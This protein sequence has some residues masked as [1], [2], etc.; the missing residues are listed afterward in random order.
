MPIKSFRG[1]IATS[2]QERIALHTNNGMTGY[3]IVKM[4]LMPT[5][6]G[7]SAY[8]NVFKVYS[9]LQTAVDGEIDFSDPTL[10]G[11]AYI[12]NNGNNITNDQTVVV[13]DNIIFNQDIHLTQIDM[14]GT[15][16]QAV[17]YHIELEKVKL[18]ISGNTVATL[19]DIRNIVSQ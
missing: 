16:S 7:T 10:L 4:E 3:R 5:N 18:D 2:G 8:E 17:N 14:D 13:F 1:Q 6:P 9:V 11:A 19:K 12:A 15:P